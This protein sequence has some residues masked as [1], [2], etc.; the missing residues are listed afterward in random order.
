M[1]RIFPSCSKPFSHHINNNTIQQMTNNTVWS[2]KWNWNS[3]ILLY[4]VLLYS[5]GIIVFLWYDCIPL[6]LLYSSG[7]IILLC[8]QSLL[9]YQA[10]TLNGNGHSRNIWVDYKVWQKKCNAIWRREKSPEPLGSAKRGNL[11]QIFFHGRG[12]SRESEEGDALLF[13]NT[14]RVLVLLGCITRHVELNH[15]CVYHLL[16]DFQRGWW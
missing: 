2:V 4:R 3:C 12:L 9:M 6:V 14:F 15:W 5:S 11:L 8:S 10:A 13:V 1:P 7:I 16:S